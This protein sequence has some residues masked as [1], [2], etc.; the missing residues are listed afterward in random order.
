MAHAE[1][2]LNLTEFADNMVASLSDGKAA[3][4]DEGFEDEGYL[5]EDDKK[6][7]RKFVGLVRG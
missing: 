3:E 7:V 1:A 5:S 6:P 4:E 2:I